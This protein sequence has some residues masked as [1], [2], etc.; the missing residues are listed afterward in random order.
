MLLTVIV[1]IVV[2]IIVLRVDRETGPRR[3][4]L[5]CNTLRHRD[6][7]L[8]I[9]YPRL[10]AEIHFEISV[11]VHR[12]DLPRLADYLTH[13]RRNTADAFKVR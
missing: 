13:R 7:A 1:V 11:A 12:H 3:W 10:T 9:Q 8:R 5:T 2:I 4:H 6:A